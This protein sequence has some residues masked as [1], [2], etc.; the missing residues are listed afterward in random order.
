MLSDDHGCRD[1]VSRVIAHRAINGLSVSSPNTASY[2]NA[3]VHLPTSVLHTLARQ[4]A[5]ELHA[6]AADEWKWNGRDIFI[7]D[8]S[9]V[10][11]P[12]TEEH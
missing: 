12:D 3:C 7:S 5:G 8:G 6:S 11:M 1:A 10:S 2:C 9:H 4:T